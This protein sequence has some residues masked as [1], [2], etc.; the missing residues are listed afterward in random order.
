MGTRMAGPQPNPQ[1][2]QFIALD[3]VPIL[4]HS[5]RAFAAAPRVTSIYLAVRKPEM[6]RLARDGLRAARQAGDSRQELRQNAASALIIF[7]CAKP[8]P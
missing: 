3:G 2:K 4:I 5:L 8:C 1:P 7:E 6:Q